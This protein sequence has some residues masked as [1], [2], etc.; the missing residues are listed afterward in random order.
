[1]LKFSL[2]LL[3]LQDKNI[4]DHEHNTDNYSSYGVRLELRKSEKLL[5]LGKNIW[6]VVNKI[7]MSGSKI[8]DC[9]ASVCIQMD[10]S[11]SDES[12]STRIFQAC[13]SQSH[14]TNRKT[15]D[16][17]FGRYFI[18][19]KIT[20]NGLNGIRDVVDMKQNKFDGTQRPCKSS[21][22]KEFYLVTDGTNFQH[23]LKIK[24]K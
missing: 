5:E 12:E 1:M 17:M 16:S 23:V 22:K 6:D 9:L 15:N 2:P 10:Y 24:N 3:C 18:L 8:F 13:Q 21:R 11:H 19:T 4:I 7:E 20:F 14:C